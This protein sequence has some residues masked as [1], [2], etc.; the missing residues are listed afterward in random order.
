[1]LRAVDQLYMSS[2]RFIV[3]FGELV[4]VEYYVMANDAIYTS[5]Y[6]LCECTTYKDDTWKLYSRLRPHVYNVQSA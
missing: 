5:E 3:H 4:S 2:I 1:M 6:R